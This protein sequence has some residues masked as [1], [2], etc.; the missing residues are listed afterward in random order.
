MIFIIHIGSGYE[1]L[2]STVPTPVFDAIRAVD[3]MPTFLLVDTAAGE[4]SRTE[5]ATRTVEAIGRWLRAD[6]PSYAEAEVG[7]SPS[8]DAYAIDA[9]RD[10]GMRRDDSDR[11]VRSFDLQEWQG[12]QREAGDGPRLGRAQGEA[13]AL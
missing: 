7:E 6:H 2:R 11:R 12:R 9:E 8:H 10:G 4:V 5:P 13:P 1:Q 3:R